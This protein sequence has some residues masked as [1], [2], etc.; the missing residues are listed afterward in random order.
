MCELTSGLF[1]FHQWKCVPLMELVFSF[2]CSHGGYHSS[3]MW[4]TAALMC[5]SDRREYKEKSEEL[6]GKQRAGASFL[7]QSFLSLV[8]LFPSTFHFPLSRVS[9]RLVSATAAASV[10][11]VEISKKNVCGHFCVC[12]YVYAIETF[13]RYSLTNVII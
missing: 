2:A 11:L 13:H 1:C 7:S 6:G 9:D 12:L 8:L 3:L 4:D 10:H 5:C